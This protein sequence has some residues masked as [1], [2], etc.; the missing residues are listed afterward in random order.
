MTERFVPLPARRGH[1]VAAAATPSFRVTET[2]YPP[3]LVVGRHAHAN[4]GLTI[5]LRGALLESYGSRT[6]E[7]A[8]PYTLLARPPEER[9]ADRIQSQGAANL[10]IELKPIETPILEECARAFDGVRQLRHPRLT[11]LARSLGAELRVCD[12]AQPLVVE[13]LALEIVGIASRGR[14]A[15]RPR[16]AP[17]WLARVHERLEG[18]FP[19]HLKMTDLARE[20]G[21]HPV[22]LA[23]AFRSHYGS[24]PGDYLRRVRI[25]WSARQLRA[26]NARPLAEI[27]LEA[28]FSDQS[29][30]IRVFRRLLGTTPG[31][32]MR[33][34]RAPSR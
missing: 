4:P 27:A 12:T 13:G 34:A 23:R 28:G 2:F 5:T 16:M 24:S 3:G 32:A 9:H 10:E 26:R 30:F 18:S 7:N 8:S 6:F 11:Q 22:S 33:Q 29:H 17:P 1:A 31:E 14:G 21:V 25:E 15:G 20:A 19:Q